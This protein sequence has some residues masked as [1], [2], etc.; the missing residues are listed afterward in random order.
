MSIMNEEA[1]LVITWYGFA[2]LLNRP[3]GGWVRR[4]IAMKD[5]AGTDLH[6]HEDVI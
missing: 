4:R 3:I 2:Q 5:A 6:H 1:I